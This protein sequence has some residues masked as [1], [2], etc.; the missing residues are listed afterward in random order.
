[1]DPLRFWRIISEFTINFADAYRIH[2][3][4]RAIIMN[5]SSVAQI[6]NESILSFREFTMTSLSVTRIHNK[7]M[8]FSRIHY[9]FTMKCSNSLLIYSLFREFTMN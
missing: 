5:S 2:Y 3:L 4:F 7:F 6:Q 1:M 9:E 8:A